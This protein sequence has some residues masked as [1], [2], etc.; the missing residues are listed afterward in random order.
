MIILTLKGWLKLGSL[1]PA[2]APACVHIAGYSHLK[3][4]T[5]SITPL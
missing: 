4:H 2:T 5:N 1:A 3:P